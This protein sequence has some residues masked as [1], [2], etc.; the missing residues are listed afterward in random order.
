[1]V[2]GKYSQSSKKS[3]EIFQVNE[4]IGLNWVGAVWAVMQL[5]IADRK[6]K[7]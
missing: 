1:M 7:S 4:D 6:R 2:K 3:T 5:V